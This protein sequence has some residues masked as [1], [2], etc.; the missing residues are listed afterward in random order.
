MYV[1]VCILYSTVLYE[2]YCTVLPHKAKT[3]QLHIICK[4]GLFINFMNKPSKNRA[5]N[6]F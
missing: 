5:E 1:P 2:V 4:L 6:L 3:T